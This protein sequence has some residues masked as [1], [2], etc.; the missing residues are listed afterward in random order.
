[1]LSNVTANAGSFTQDNLAIASALL[2]NY[3]S[4]DDLSPEVG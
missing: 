1:M 3:V 2:S 4:N